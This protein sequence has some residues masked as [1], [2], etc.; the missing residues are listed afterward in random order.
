MHVRCV[1]SRLKAISQNFSLIATPSDSARFEP[2]VRRLR[3][4]DISFVSWFNAC[5]TRLT[6]SA[7]GENASFQEE[8]A[9][10]AIFAH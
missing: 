2:P 10:S 7:C 1:A 5:F 8:M 4:F 9:I 6:A 3:S